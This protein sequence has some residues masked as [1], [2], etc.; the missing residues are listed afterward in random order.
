M[1]ERG[2]FREDLYYRLMLFEC[3]LTP[4]RNDRAGLEKAIEKCFSE[5][6]GRYQKTI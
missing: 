4:L 2:E 6:R 5:Q 1:V 3:P